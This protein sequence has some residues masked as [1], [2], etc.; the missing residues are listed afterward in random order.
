MSPVYDVLSSTGRTEGVQAAV[1]AVRRGELIVLP[2]DT[3]Y[4]VGADAFDPVA[5][6]RLLEAKGRGRQQPPPVL[7]ADVRTL[8]ALAVEVPEYARALVARYWPGPLTVVVRAQ[9]SLAWDLGDTNGTVALR[10]PDQELA[11][12][13]L[14]QTGPLA[15]SSANRTGAPAAQTVVQAATQ[16]GAAVEVYL[17]GGAVHGSPEAGGAAVASTIV[18]CTRERPVVLR[19]GPISVAEVQ[20]CA[21]ELAPGSPAAPDA[22]SPG[23]PSGVPEG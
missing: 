12:E 18:D 22:D 3:V 2:T 19:P 21:D 4:G 11:L 6:Q 8:D 17:D 15:V 20:A 10:M 13:L 7:V 5:V 14:T 9:P 16:L 23:A 1:D